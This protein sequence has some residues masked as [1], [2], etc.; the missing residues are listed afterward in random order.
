M[1]P[2]KTERSD[3][4]SKAATPPDAQAIEI[5]RNHRPQGS[6]WSFGLCRNGQITPEMGI[7]S[8]VKHPHDPAYPHLEWPQLPQVMQ[9]STMRMPYW[10]QLGQAL[11]RGASSPTTLAV[12]SDFS[13]CPSPARKPVATM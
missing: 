11:P 8:W 3:G 9:P 7:L 12:G 10:P 6:R 5:T 1:A 13:P 2:T 4:A